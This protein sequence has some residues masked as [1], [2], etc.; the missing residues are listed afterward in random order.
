MKQTRRQRQSA[1]RRHNAVISATTYGNGNRAIAANRPRSNEFYRNDFITNKTYIMTNKTYIAPTLLQPDNHAVLLI[2]FQYEQLITARS[3]ET[4]LVV[5]A[6]VLLAR[7]AK[8]FNVPTLLCTGLVSHQGMISE[9]QAVY[10]DQIPLDRTNLNA[11]E[12]ERIVAWAQ[13]TGRKKLVI[14][15]LWTESCVSMSALSALSAGYEVY[16]ITDASAGGS[17]D[18]HDMAVWRMIQAGAIPM[19]AGNYLK[20]VQ[21]DW[22]REETASQVREIYHQEGSSYGQAVLWMSELFKHKE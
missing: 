13:N 4:E 19:A 9:V 17:K 21:R 3:G 5:S 6:A 10:P 20:E 12:D 18:S 22:A 8:L 7:S 2:D 14:A 11:F 1:G 15:G 16:I